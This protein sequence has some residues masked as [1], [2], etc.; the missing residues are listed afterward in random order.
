GISEEDFRGSSAWRKRYRVMQQAWDDVFSQSKFTDEYATIIQ[1]QLDELYKAKRQLYDQRRE[2]NKVLVRDA[3]AD[4]LTEELIKAA[5]IVPLKRY[6]SAF[7]FK[8]NS[9]NKEALLCFSD[10][11]YGAVSNNIWNVY[12][13]EI[14]IQRVSKLFDS[15]SSALREHN[16]K[17]LHIALLGDFV[18]GAIHTGVRVAA[19]ENTCEQ[20]MHVSE[21][22]ANFINEISVYVD[23]VVVYSTYGNHARTIQNKNDSIHADNMERVIPWWLRQRLKD[24]QKVDILDSEYYEFIYMQ[25]CGCNIVCTHGDLDKFKDIGITVNSLFTKKYGKSIDYTFSADKHHLESFEQFGIE[26]TLVGSLCGTDEYAN[27]KRLYSNPTQTLC[28][29]TPDDGKLCSY[30]INL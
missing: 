12:N 30:N 14:C 11:H 27:N 15:V 5:N 4:H 9:S 23:K 20:L 28:I 8:N 2:Y 21:I 22:L 29:F 24:N 17:T 7:A 18:H 16:V 6:S 3:R 10:W 19:E 1:E 26:S 13:I 25:I